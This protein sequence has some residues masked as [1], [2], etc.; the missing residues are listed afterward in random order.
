MCAV[1]LLHALPGLHDDLAETMLLGG[2]HLNQLAPP[3]QERIEFALVVGREQARRGL[4][5]L[6]EAREE[7]RI[8]PIGLRQS[9]RRLREVAHVPRIHDHDRQRCGGEGARH[10]ELVAAS[11]FEHDQRRG[12]RPHMLEQRADPRLVVRHRRGLV[13]RAH[14]HVE[15][16]LR[17]VNPDPAVCGLRHRSSQQ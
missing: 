2:E 15:R 10:R 16:G 17:N 9:T 8:E 6:R 1:R 4:H 3:R 14:L 5:L 13:G 11:R 12:D 7:R